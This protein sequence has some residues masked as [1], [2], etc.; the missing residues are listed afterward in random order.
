MNLTDEPIALIDGEW[1]G[2]K[3]LNA[4]KGTLG[5]DVV[6]DI[7]KKL[8]VDYERNT[9]NGFGHDI[10]LDSP[11]KTL[12][13]E[14]KNTAENFEMS[15]D[16]YNTNVHLRFENCD[17]DSMR[18]LDI[19]RFN[20]KSPKVILAMLEDNVYVVES[21]VQVTDN[22]THNQ[23]VKNVLSYY[24]KLLNNSE[25]SLE[26]TIPKEEPEAPSESELLSETMSYPF[27]SYSALELEYWN[28]IASDVLFPLVS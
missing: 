2:I 21:E 9:I 24:E 17:P 8:N 18:I 3:R 26:L 4:H 5:V 27:S 1:K 19:T 6:E 22:T 13:V 14:K 7:A 23:A 28:S 12:S 11:N 25:P 10:T 15:L 20:P 16:W